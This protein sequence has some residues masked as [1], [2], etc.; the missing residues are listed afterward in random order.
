[1][2]NID[3]LLVKSFFAPAEA[4]L[5]AAVALFGRLLYFASWSIISVMFPVSAAVP[6]GKPNGVLRT[7]LGLVGGIAGLFI[8]LVT[9]LPKFLIV[10]VLG[11][12]FARADDLL[13]MYAIG[14]AL[15]ALSVV[16]M[17]YEMSRKIANTGWLQL[18]V[19]GLLIIAI[20]IFHDSLQQVI[21]VQI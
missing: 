11:H 8:L 3:I 9:L 15:Y 21:V 7:A 10:M 2:T 16:L 20:T 6:D 19:S 5:Y 13:P 14:T 18:V 4:G 17:A 1:I 12:S